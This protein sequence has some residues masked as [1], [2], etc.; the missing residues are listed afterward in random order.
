MV[1]YQK[2]LEERADG[3]SGWQKEWICCLFKFWHEFSSAWRVDP[4]PGKKCFQG[5]FLKYFSHDIQWKH[6][7]LLQSW[8]KR[9]RHWTRAR[10]CLLVLRKFPVAEISAGSP[11]RVT[12]NQWVAIKPSV[13]SASKEA[14]WALGTSNRVVPAHSSLLGSFDV[15]S[16]VP[17]Y[18][19][20]LWQLLP[21]PLPTSPVRSDLPWSGC[22]GIGANFTR[23]CRFPEATAGLGSRVTF[24]T[25][26]VLSWRR[27]Q[28]CPEGVFVS[29]DSLTLQ[30]QAT[31]FNFLELLW[32]S[33]SLHP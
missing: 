30:L 22:A 27:E 23:S 19:K 12:W 6:I 3:E 5:G 26:K 7:W 1:K 14:S 13:F 33:L 31:G 4:Q 10:W 2:T 16:V 32:L 18:L 28:Q 15:A 29:P 9:V 11:C 25:Q 21:T 24:R 8:V 17:K 20:L